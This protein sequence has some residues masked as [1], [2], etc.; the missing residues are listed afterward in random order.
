MLGL[1]AEAPEPA[2]DL[3]IDKCLSSILTLRL[4]QTMAR[5]TGKFFLK[6]IDIS[7]E[8]TVSRTNKFLSFI[9]DIVFQ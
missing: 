9:V 3:L 2:C 8:A 1:T 4:E 6:G 5:E 7:F